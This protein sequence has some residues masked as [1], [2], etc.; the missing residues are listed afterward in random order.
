MRFVR[1]KEEHLE[2]ILRWRTSERVTRYMFTDVAYDMERQREWFRSVSADESSRYWV[3]VSGET[4]IGLV[5]LN[6]IHPV[7]RS[8]HWAFYIGEPEYGT[9]AAVI[10]P[11]LY[12]YAFDS[13]GLNKLI[14][15]VME[16][17]TAVR[18]IHLM[19]GAREVGV[20]RQ[21]VWKY[22]KF[23]DVV[24]FEMLAEEWRRIERKYAKFAGEFEE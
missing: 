22:G 16:D 7:N 20:Y 2:K 12:R 8:A 1:V 5:S 17:N 3:V 14:G 9:A 10:G 21:H 23:H 13:L 11:C 19:H 15:E 4:E 6:K 24:V 18:R